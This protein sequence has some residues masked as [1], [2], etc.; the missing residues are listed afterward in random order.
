M[1]F[2][3]AETC[4]WPRHSINEEFFTSDTRVEVAVDSNSL[5]FVE[6]NAFKI[7]VASCESWSSD[8]HSNQRHWSLGRSLK[9]DDKSWETLFDTFKET[10]DDI[11]TAVRTTGGTL[12][13]GDI[14]D[15]MIEGNTSRENPSY[16]HKDINPMLFDLTSEKGTFVIPVFFAI[17]VVN[18]SIC[19]MSSS[20]LSIIKHPERMRVFRDFN[21]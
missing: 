11:P 15:E 10:W 16:S 1:E 13:V 4:T 3:A 20:N 6:L 14:Q 2:F 21:V 5:E 18:D 9:T 17:R 12:F 8:P 7:L 19:S